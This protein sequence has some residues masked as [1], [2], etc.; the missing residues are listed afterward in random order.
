M[1]KEMLKKGGCY[2]EKHFGTRLYYTG[3][4]REVENYYYGRGYVKETVY[5]FNGDY[6]AKGIEK[7]E[8]QL[9]FLVEC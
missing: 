3:E 4:T 6:D 1:T 9:R 2:K 8:D 5:I 7:T